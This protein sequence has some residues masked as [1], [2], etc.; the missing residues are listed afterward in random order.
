MGIKEV[1]LKDA[2]SAA[3]G[4]SDTFT[5]AVRLKNQEWENVSDTLPV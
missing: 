1:R 3:A 5:E 4:A 2:L